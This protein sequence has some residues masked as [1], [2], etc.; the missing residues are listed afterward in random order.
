MI[1][2][3]DRGGE[4]SWSH[5]VFLYSDRAKIRLKINVIILVPLRVAT[6]DYVIS[7]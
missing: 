5:G 1:Q 6:C 3:Y 4:A 7:H 2:R